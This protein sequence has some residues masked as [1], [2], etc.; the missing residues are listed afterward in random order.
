[1]AAG[2][3]SWAS[4]SREMYV[5]TIHGFCLELLK[6]E[7]PEFLKHEVL[8]EVRQALFIAR[9]PPRAVSSRARS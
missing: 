1:M 6:T 7:A 8:D 5:G 3:P 4:A 9:A 2:A